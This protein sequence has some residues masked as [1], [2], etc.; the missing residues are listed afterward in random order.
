MGSVIRHAYWK[1]RV[2]FN[3]SSV[4]NQYSL[5]EK[6]AKN[7]L[8]RHVH[9]LMKAIHI[10]SA[11]RKRWFLFVKNSFL[12]SFTPAS[13]SFEIFDF[14]WSISAISS[15]SSFWHIFNILVISS[16]LISS[17]SLLEFESD[18]WCSVSSF[19]S[20]LLTPVHFF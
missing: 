16:I 8:E 12:L 6:V 15:P 7:V 20:E 11:K 13:R 14:K 4:N 17:R 19:P 18:L 10:S 2:L 9:D 3:P 5:F 1:L